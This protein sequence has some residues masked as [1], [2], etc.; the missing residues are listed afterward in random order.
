MPPLNYEKQ[1][2]TIDLAYWRV[3]EHRSTNP[4]SLSPG[5]AQRWWRASGRGEANMDSARLARAEVRSRP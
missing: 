1:G 2:R 3:P 5:H 4:M